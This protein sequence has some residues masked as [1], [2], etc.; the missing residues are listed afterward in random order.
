MR[1]N[2]RENKGERKRQRDGEHSGSA[3]EVRDYRSS[4]QLMTGRRL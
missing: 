2:E 1:E 3:E 4:K